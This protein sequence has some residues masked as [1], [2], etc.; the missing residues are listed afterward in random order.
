MRWAHFDLGWLEVAPAGAPIVVGTNVAVIVRHLGFWSVNGCR[1]VNVIERSAP[2]PAFGFVYGTL[3][4]HA[5][6]G[7]EIFLVSLS[8]ASGD[9]TYSIRAASRARAPLARLGYP[10]TRAFQARFRRDSLRAMATA[11]T[12]RRG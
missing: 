4:T 9:V 2:V 1:I 7:E 11:V 5:E 6:A 3:E 12:D 10:V 8:P